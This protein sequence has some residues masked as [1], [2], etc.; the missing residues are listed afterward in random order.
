MKISGIDF[1]EPL[2][3]ALRDGELIVFA[4]AGVSMGEPAKLPDFK[5]LTQAIGQGTGEELQD[6]EPED[7]YLG[8]APSPERCPCP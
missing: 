6:R 2:L 3:N 7:D 1:P 5:D 8:R 4:G